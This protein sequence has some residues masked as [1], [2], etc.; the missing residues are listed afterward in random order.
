MNDDDD[1]QSP[2]RKCLAEAF[3]MKAMILVTAQIVV[4]YGIVVGNP[5]N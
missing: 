3:S 2:Q 5:S 1:S 4:V